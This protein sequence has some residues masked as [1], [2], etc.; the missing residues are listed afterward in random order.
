MT[1]LAEGLVAVANRFSVLLRDSL[2]GSDTT[3]PQ[4]RA[5]SAL[6]A[7]EPQRITA[8]AESQHVTQPAMTS[9]VNTLERRGLVARSSAHADRRGIEVRLT[10]AGRDLMRAVREAR[11]HTIDEHLAELDGAEHSRLE[12]GIPALGRLNEII[13]SRR[14][15]S[16]ISAE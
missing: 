13:R 4:A 7:H 16:P 8:L 15:A 11:I 9:L 12:A 2:R 1:E 6:F 5:L 14:S 3:L 10:T